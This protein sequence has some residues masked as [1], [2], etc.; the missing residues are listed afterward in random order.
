LRGDLKWSGGTECVC[1]LDFNLE[2]ADTALYIIYVYSLKRLACVTFPGFFEERKKRK[3][4]RY[5]HA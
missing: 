5:T 4:T 3:K 1:R 2:R